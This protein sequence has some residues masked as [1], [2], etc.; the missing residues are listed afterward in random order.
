MHHGRLP[1]KR[2]LKDVAVGHGAVG[3]VEGVGL[4]LDAEHGQVLATG[5]LQRT[6]AIGSHAD[7]GTLADG[8]NLA[9]NLI[10]ALALQD[11]VKLLVG[12]VGVQETAVLTR[13]E[14]LERQFATCS[15]YGLTCE[16][17]TLDGHSAHWQLV[18]NN[19]IYLTYAYCAEI[20]TCCNCLNLFH[21]SYLFKCYY[22][23]LTVTMM[24]VSECR[25]KLASVVPS[26]SII[27][28]S[29]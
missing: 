29:P 25:T 8:E 11:D 16:H 1:V 12:L 5:V 4:I 14:C 18:L 3:L 15:T 7:D 28:T 20:L 10:L 6:L 21:N 23:V 26:V 19:L 27:A 22:F 9:V 2:F 17:L 13:N 24:R